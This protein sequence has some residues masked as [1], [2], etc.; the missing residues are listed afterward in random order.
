MSQQTISYYGTRD[1]KMNLLSD[2]ML[3]IQQVYTTYHMRD[4]FVNELPSFREAFI[5]C[6]D[7]LWDAGWLHGERINTRRHTTFSDDLVTKTAKYC[8]TM[9]SEWEKYERRWIGD[10]D[11]TNSGIIAMKTQIELLSSLYHHISAT[12]TSN[13]E[14]KLT[15]EN[16][17]WTFDSEKGQHPRMDRGNPEAQ[18]VDSFHNNPTSHDHIH[19]GNRGDANHGRVGDV[20][21]ML[22]QLEH[23]I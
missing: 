22:C 1:Q 14:I 6:M 16:G 3:E 19:D 15:I 8:S 4:R 13:D 9:C 21:E 17:R 10:I 7:L 11:H 2:L 23:Y 5:A 18:P 12:D 20:N